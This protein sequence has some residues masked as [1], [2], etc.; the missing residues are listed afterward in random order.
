[1]I[2][3]ITPKFQ[4]DGSSAT[5]LHHLNLLPKT[6]QHNLLVKWN[7]D[8][9]HRDIEE[10]LESLAHDPECSDMVKKAIQDITSWSSIT[11]SIKGILTAGVIKSIKY[12][13]RKVKKMLTSMKK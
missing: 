2:V 12:S 3:D 8:G 1:M 7:K 10:V 6:V 11:Q 4:Q 5:T 13:S 9:R